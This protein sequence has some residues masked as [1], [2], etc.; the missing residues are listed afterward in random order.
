ME[1]QHAAKITVSRDWLTKILGFP[2][3][4]L[5]DQANMDDFWR[6]S[7]ITFVIE[8]PDLPKVTPGDMLQT[9][10]P[11]MRSELVVIED[12]Q[13]IN[14]VKPSDGSYER[15]ARIEPETE[16]FIIGGLLCIAGESNL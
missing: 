12:G 11:T 6:P 5:H 9:I 8:H 13:V 15:I 4:V 1:E 3:G 10:T 7:E 14:Y 2:N 16:T